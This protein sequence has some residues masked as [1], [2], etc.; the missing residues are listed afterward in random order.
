[1][2]C[3]CDEFPECIHSQAAYEKLFPRIGEIQARTAENEESYL[4]MEAASAAMAKAEGYEWDGSV[5][6][7]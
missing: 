5:E 3:N 4:Q 2:P 1:M 6:A 7:E